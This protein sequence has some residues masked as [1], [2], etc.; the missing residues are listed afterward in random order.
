L[1]DAAE[2][3]LFGNFNKKRKGSKKKIDL[4]PPNNTACLICKNLVKYSKVYNPVHVCEFCKLKNP[5]GYKQIIDENVNLITKQFN[6]L[7]STCMECLNNVEDSV[8]HCRNRDCS[9]LYERTKVKRVL[10]KFQTSNL[11]CKDIQLLDW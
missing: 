10:S 1:G 4:D 6:D 5:N 3:T 8:I 7:W 2:T 11:L 9:T